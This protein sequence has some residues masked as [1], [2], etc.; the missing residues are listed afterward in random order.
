MEKKVKK[1]EAAVEA[2]K[3][4]VEKENKAEKELEKEEDK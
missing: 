4:D 1:A 2:E 3:D